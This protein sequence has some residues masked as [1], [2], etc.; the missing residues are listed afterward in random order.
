MELI[1]RRENLLSK[2]PPLFSL[3]KYIDNNIVYNPGD[4]KLVI[5]YCFFLNDV[6]IL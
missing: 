6:I 1:Y 4:N 2:N 3:K 5:S